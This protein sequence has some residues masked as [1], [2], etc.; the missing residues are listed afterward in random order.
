MEK[1]VLL[2]PGQQPMG[3]HGHA[4]VHLAPLSASITVRALRLILVDPTN[5]SAGRK[6]KAQGRRLAFGRTA[7][8]LARPEEAYDP[9][10]HTWRETGWPSEHST[11]TSTWERALADGSS[12]TTRG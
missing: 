5:V 3:G 6:T 4:D 11:S 12:E 2:V 9:Q 7:C 1:E 10:S 8:A